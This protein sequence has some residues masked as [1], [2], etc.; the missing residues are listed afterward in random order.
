MVAPAGHGAVPVLEDQGRGTLGHDEPV[1]PGVEGARVA[2]TWRAPSCWR[3]RPWPPGACWPRSRRRWRRRSGP[4]ATRRAA[5]AMAWVPAAQAVQM[6]SDGPRQPRRMEMPA[7]PALAIIMGTSRGETRS[8]PLL[9]VDA[10][11]VGQRLEA[12]RPR[13]RT[14]RRPWPGRRRDR[15]P[16]RR[17]CRP[18]RWRIGRSG[19]AGATSLGPNQSLGVEAAHLAARPPKG[20]AARPTA[21]PRPTPQ[22]VTAPSPVTATRRPRMGPSGPIPSS[23]RAWR[24]SGRRP[25]RSW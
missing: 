21:R 8:A 7:A 12:R 2:P 22:H 15:P 19:R 1:T 3:R 23:I 25:A 4:I 13:W 20:G 9:V 6:T 14:S 16:P 5:A 18:R 11:L 10:D 17:P 24:R